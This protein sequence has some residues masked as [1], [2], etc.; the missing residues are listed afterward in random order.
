VGVTSFLDKLE[1]SFLTQLDSKD[2]PKHLDPKDG[3]AVQAWFHEA[4]GYWLL[5]HRDDL[6]AREWGRRGWA[7]CVLKPAESGELK[8]SY[9]VKPHCVEQIHA[10]LQDE[11][12]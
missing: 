5:T 6:L 10:W 11:I 4:F 8:E 9:R 1:A 7:D 12:D 3:A 2:I